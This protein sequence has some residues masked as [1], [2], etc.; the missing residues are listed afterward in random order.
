MIKL[1]ID[2]PSSPI[3]DRWIRD[4]KKATEA[5]CKAFEAGDEIEVSAIYKRRSIKAAYFTSKGGFFSGKCAYCECYVEDFQHGDIE[6]FRPKK[7][8]TDEDDNVVLVEDATGKKVPHPGYYWLAYNWRNLLLSCTDCNQP[9]E[10]KGRKVGKHNRFPV[11]G[12]HALHSEEVADE[13]PL[14]INPCEEDPSEHFSFDTESGIMRGETDRGEMCERIFALNLRDRLPEERRKACKEVK[15]M[16]AEIL[17]NSSE[18]ETVR[19]VLQEYREG[20]RSYSM[21]G[22]AMIEELLR[23]LSV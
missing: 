9:G 10:I 17:W 16:F 21:A 2:A 4:C 7:G 18:K 1:N 8:V 13:E 12:K 22:R 23:E 14:L 20:R 11:R 6:H 5:L 19:K 15:A 3:W